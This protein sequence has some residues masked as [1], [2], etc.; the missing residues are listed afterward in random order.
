MLPPLDHFEGLIGGGALE[1]FKSMY[2]KTPNEIT[3]ME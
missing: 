1:N 2:T 3:S